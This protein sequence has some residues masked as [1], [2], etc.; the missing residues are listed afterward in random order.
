MIGN[1]YFW[2]GVP[3]RQMKWESSALESGGKSITAEEET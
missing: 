2:S 3:Y 1:S